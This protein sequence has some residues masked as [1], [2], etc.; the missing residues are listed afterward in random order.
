MAELTFQ[1]LDGMERG[2]VY[3]DIPT[4]FTV[5]REE[6]NAIQLQDERVSRYHLKIQEQQ[7]QI[8]LTDLDSTN[9]TRVNGRPVQVHVLRVGDQISIGRCL[10]LYGSP[11]Q[12]QQRIDELR[13]RDHQAADQL[14]GLASALLRK[15]QEHSQ[16]RGPSRRAE[17]A[18]GSEKAE[19]E[20][21]PEIDGFLFPDGPPP[22]PQRLSLD[23]RAQ[24]SDLLASVHEQ[25]L[26]VIQTA[27]E[28]NKP[29]KPEKP[30]VIEWDQWQRLLAVEMQLARYLRQIAEPEG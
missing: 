4:P 28:A 13:Q 25:L 5:G 27:R 18:E 12:I 15:R 29:A 26:E 19:S 11:E 22:L 10:L 7:G 16:G 1:V 2:L 14:L 17:Q 3:A 23:Q 30:V 8:I 24:L 9:G 20:E 21:I 6:G